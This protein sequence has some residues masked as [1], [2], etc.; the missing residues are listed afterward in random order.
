MKSLAIVGMACRFPRG[1]NSIQL[2]WDAL[3]S[4]FSAIDQVPPDRWT[5]DRYFSSNAIAKGKSYIR[6]GGF[7]TQDVQAF[8]AGFFG[9]SPRDAENMDPQQRL[10]LEVVW[11]A[12]ENSGMLL[13]EYARRSVGVYVGGFML[14]HM[15]SQMGAANRS[16]INQNTAAGMMMTML[17]NRI[18]HTFDFRGPSLSI[19][20]ACSSSLVAF[21][22]ACQDIWRGHS[23]M[24]VVGGAN[25][26]LRPEYPMGMC[27]GQ[28]LSRDGEC[29]SFDERGDGYGRGEGAGVVLVKSLDD[30]V[31][32]GDPIL[33]TVIATGTNQ[34]GRTPG[35][36]MPSGEAQKALIQSVCDQYQIDPASIDYVECHGTG[37][38]IGDPT[39][40][41][42]IG[43][44]YGAARRA[45]G[46][47]PVILGSIKSTTG[48][49]E[50]AAGVAGVI[51]ATLTLLHRETSPLANLQTPNPGIDTDGLHVRLSDDAYSLG[52]D[53]QSP[54]RIAVNS[55]G[56]GGSN[57]HA[58]LQSAPP[59]TSFLAEAGL[60]A[61]EG[62]AASEVDTQ[63][64]VLPITARSENAVRTLAADYISLL[65][66]DCRLDDVLHSTVHHRAR[67]SHRAIV[68]GTK[69]EELT[70]ALTAVATEQEHETAVL[71]TQPYE[72]SNLPVIVFTG[73]G[74]QW[75]AMG[76]E[77]YRSEP[78]YRAAVDEADAVFQE[79]SGFSAVAEMLKSEEES[80]IHLTEYAQ[81]GNFLIQIGLWKLLQSRGVQAGAFVGHSV[82]ELA[83]AWAAGVLDL[84]SAMTVCFHRSR[85][86]ATCKGTGA[87]LAVGLG[88]EAIEARI[89]ANCG[90]VSV[91]AANGPGNITIAGDADALSDIAAELTREDIFNR[92][93]QVEVPYHSPMMDPLMPRL[94]EALADIQTNT[95]SRISCN[96]LRQR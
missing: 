67:L 69:R 59:S 75:W 82:G 35:V 28:F 93:L 1:L 38:A 51:K 81:P 52:D 16:A 34:D 61:E 15:I 44:L 74:P 9:I 5:A 77:L 30:A 92:L 56:Y 64:F 63:P 49:M 91:A 79:V 27:K 41:E 55:F 14:D 78:V 6:R 32:D 24:A 19:D 65:N 33:A 29:K 23:E 53:L 25:V 70:A 57:A 46:K 62:P 20:T 43:R 95:P 17:S 94:A 84:R 68:S 87:M 90:S 76:Q 8:D 36:S 18:S 50:A 40:S 96:Q 72:G 85:L 42:A 7:L 10:L 86:Q 80:Q 58:V 66:S 37:T 60:Q 31:R 11:E 88:R 12:F 45:A 47:P 39:E 4:R 83:S 71:G 13:P 54:V 89:A 26:M 21:H 2:L 48:H 3:Q 22:Y 73:M